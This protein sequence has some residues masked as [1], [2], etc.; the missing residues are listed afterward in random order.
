MP[1]YGSAVSDLGTVDDN[2]NSS[3]IYI[4]KFRVSQQSPQLD[5][6]LL[7]AIILSFTSGQPQVNGKQLILH[8]EIIYKYFTGN[9][10]YN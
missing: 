4:T 9:I 6:S 10:V 8:D 2:N 3:V 1:K 5:V 7:V